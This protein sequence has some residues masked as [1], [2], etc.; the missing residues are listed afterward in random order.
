M[1]FWIFSEMRGQSRKTDVEEMQCLGRVGT[2]Y[3]AGHLIEQLHKHSL[4]WGTC[5]HGLGEMTWFER[6]SSGC[7]SSMFSHFLLTGDAVM[8]PVAQWFPSPKPLEKL[9]SCVQLCD[10][11]DC[12]LHRLLHP[13]DFLGKITGVGCHFLLQGIFP[14]QGLDPGLLHCRQTLYCLSH[15]G[16]H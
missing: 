4:G 11:M 9:F 16:S 7:F 5:D 8:E 10:P 15:Q 3:M 13:W 2:C 6:R 1:D 14:T 12:G